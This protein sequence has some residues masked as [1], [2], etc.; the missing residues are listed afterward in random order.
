MHDIQLNCMMIGTEIPLE[1]VSRHLGSVF[2]KRWSEVLV[3]E[4]NQLENLL[5]YQTKKYQKVILYRYGAA[6]FINFAVDE[7][8]VVID[9][10]QSVT[11]EVTNVDILRSV[12]VHRVWM[13]ENDQCKLFLTDDG[14]YPF[15]EDVFMIASHVVAQSI[16]TDMIEKEINALL[17]D[18]EDL[19][20]RIQKLRFIHK[21][22]KRGKLIAKVIRFQHDYVRTTQIFS[23]PSMTD[24]DMEFRE[25]YSKLS[26]YYELEDRFS[27]IRHKMLEL[28]NINERFS[29]MTHYRYKLRLLHLE[30]FLLAMFPLKFLVGTQL[31]QGVQ[32]LVEWIAMYLK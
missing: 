3:I 2:T 5:K 7:M 14:Y 22:K 17:D 21:G 30:V 13:A 10:V 8:R 25:M 9:F 18:A 4:K 16:A 31:K 12:D 26:A 1:A 27:V 29:E 32:A 6:T 11:N 19:I 24:N 20:S 23:A 28:K 15:S